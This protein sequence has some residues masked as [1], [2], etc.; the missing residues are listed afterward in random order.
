M[1]AG[2][3]VAFGMPCSRCGVVHAT[4]AC[5]VTFTNYT[6]AQPMT[7]ACAPVVPMQSFTCVATSDPR[8]LPLRPDDVE[9]IALRVVEL[10]DARDRKPE[11]RFYVVDHAGA[12]WGAYHDRAEAD[13]RAAYLTAAGR[14][15][16]VTERSR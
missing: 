16:L 7:P 8:A 12:G 14:P 3:P 1:S 15:A 5:P 13:E 9:R 11:P 6:Y 4:W 10:L 2:D